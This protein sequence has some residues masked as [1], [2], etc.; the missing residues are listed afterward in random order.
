MNGVS[1][2]HRLSNPS[3]RDSISRTMSG[4]NP[5]FVLFGGDMVAS[6]SNQ[7]EWDNFFEGLHSY[8]IGNNNLTIPIVPCLGNHEGNATNYYEQLALPGN[9]Q[10]Y[11]LDW[12]RSV[13]ITVLNSEANASGEQLDWLEND[14]ASHEN[15][16]WKFVLFHRPP[17]SS[18]P[19]GSWNES[20]QY[21]CPLLDKYHVDIVF[22][23]HDHDYERSKPINYTASKTSP[24]DSYS[25]G[26]MYVVSGGWGAPLHNAG[27]NWWTAYSASLYH[28][29]LVDVFANGTLNLQAMNASQS[30]FDKMHQKTPIIRE[31]PP[32][33]LLLVVM[34][35]TTLV[36]AIQKKAER[37]RK[38][39]QA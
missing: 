2:P 24:K 31:F 25:N 12:G 4:L 23:G 28:F 19:H 34:A 21:W 36:L 30:V 8:W 5:S 17:F 37:R 16:T 18:G 3:V 15:S 10:W 33:D 27:S 22:S 29:V 39:Q 7:A 26:T 9:K 13:H 38:R 20:R 1:E 35:M 11:S 14:L 6:G 32:N